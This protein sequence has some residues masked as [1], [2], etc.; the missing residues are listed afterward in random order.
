MEWISSAPATH[1]QDTMVAISL[2][3][4]LVPE[5]VSPDLAQV[6]LRTMADDECAHQ[7]GVTPASARASLLIFFMSSGP[8]TPL[9][10]P[11]INALR[12]A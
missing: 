12:R 9:F 1:F 2:P 7:E 5:A 10:S 11:S 8:A 6:C 3:F 4:A